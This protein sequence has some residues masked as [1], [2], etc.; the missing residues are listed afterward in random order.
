MDSIRDHVGQ[1]YVVGLHTYE[2][3]SVW[4]DDATLGFVS[5]V[6]EDPEHVEWHKQHPRTAVI[7]VASWDESL[8]P[9][10]WLE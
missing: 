6:S 2:V 3:V 9:V 10:K 7:S 4:G 5:C 1:R 8:M